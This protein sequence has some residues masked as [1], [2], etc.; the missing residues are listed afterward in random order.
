MLQFPTP[1][2]L[3]AA[4]KRNW[5]KFLHNQHLWRPQTVTTRLEIFA[6]AEGLP[7]SAAVTAA[8]SLLAASLV[9]V[10]VTLQ[11]QLDEYRRR[12]TEAF[13]AHPDHDVFGSLPGAKATLGLRLLPKSAACGRS[14]PTPTSCCVRRA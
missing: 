7:A 12:I 5:E 1:A 13:R 6:H 9:K 2:Q 14:I 11:A 4:G 10:L 8:K 3:Q